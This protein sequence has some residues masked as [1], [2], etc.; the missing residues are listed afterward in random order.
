MR[1]SK[2]LIKY[3]ALVFLF[4]YLFIGFFYALD[5]GYYQK[6]INRVAEGKS[7]DQVIDKILWGKSS[8]MSDLYLCVSSDESNYLL[9]I[10]L[11]KIKSLK[12]YSKEYDIEELYISGVLILGRSYF[13]EGC[14][15]KME[16]YEYIEVKSHQ[17]YFST[18]TDSMSY[19]R[20]IN[21]SS[22][23]SLKLV[24]LKNSNQNYGEEGIKIVVLSDDLLRPDSHE[25]LIEI[26]KKKVLGDKTEKIYSPVAFLGDMLL[27]PYHFYLLVQQ[28]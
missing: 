8:D 23:S 3:V 24:E 19:L 16:Q 2:K 7:V 26:E 13:R 25:L 18:L 15:K 1:S 14:D 6:N 20:K 22:S 17:A 9:N 21:Q 5:E 11:R 4:L 27:Y 28:V 12:K 10:P